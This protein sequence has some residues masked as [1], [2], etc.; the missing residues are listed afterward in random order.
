M[1]L[2]WSSAGSIAAALL[3]DR[4]AVIIGSLGASAA[5][6]LPAP[7]EGTFEAALPGAGPTLLDRTAISTVL[8]GRALSTRTDMTP[9]Q[10]YFPLDPE[11]IAHCD[12]I[13]HIPVASVV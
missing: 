5:L 9:E 12:A 2:E 10:G 4:Y 3:G 13:L 11:T 1:D 8:N 6:T 7:S